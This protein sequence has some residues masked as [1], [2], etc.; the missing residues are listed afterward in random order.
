MT[1]EKHVALEAFERIADQVIST[2]GHV[3]MDLGDSPESKEGVNRAREDVAAVERFLMSTLEERPLYLQAWDELKALQALSEGNRVLVSEAALDR[4]ERL[5]AM[6]AQVSQAESLGKIA[7]A[8][9]DANVGFWLER[10]IALGG[11]SDR[12]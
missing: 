2:A 6:A 10:A 5:V 12:G 9:G 3:T 7:E 8:L 11:A 1:G 4:A